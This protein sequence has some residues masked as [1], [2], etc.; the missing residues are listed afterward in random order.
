MLSRSNSF[1]SLDTLDTATYLDRLANKKV[2]FGSLEIKEMPM[3]LGDAPASCGAPV[4]IGWEACDIR[5]TSIRVFEQLKEE[6]RQPHEFR[7]S[8]DER[9]EILKRAG[10]SRAQIEHAASSARNDLKKRET[11]LKTYGWNNATFKLKKLL[12]RPSSIGPRAA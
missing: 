10:Y 2:R 11:S 12:T 5:R 3:E 6:P 9:A 1:A 4:T 7:L 8:S